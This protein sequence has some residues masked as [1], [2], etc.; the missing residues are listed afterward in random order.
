MKEVEGLNKHER[1]VLIGRDGPYSVMAG[2]NKTSE[3][4]DK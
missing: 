1:S 2:G 4:I 3:T